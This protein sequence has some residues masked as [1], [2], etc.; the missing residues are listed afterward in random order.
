MARYLPHLLWCTS[1]ASGL[2]FFVAPNGCERNCS[3]SGVSLGLHGAQ[4]AVRQAIAQGMTEDI[5]VHIADGMYYLDKTLVFT[6]EDSGQR[7][8]T[9]RWKASGSNATISGGLR[10]TGWARN[11]TSGIYEASVPRG[12]QSRNLFVNGWA[13]NYARQELNHT[14]FTATNYTFNWNT[15]EYDW[16][17]TTPGIANAELR[18]IGSFTDRYAPINAV[19]DRELIMS[20]WC[21]RNQVMGYDDFAAPFADFGLF[22][23]NALALLDEGGEFFLDS[24]CGKVYYMPLQGEDMS[25][26]DTHLGILEALVVISGTY[27]SPAH[28]ISMEGLNFVSINHTSRLVCHDFGCFT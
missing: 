10:V 1:V 24:D 16:L 23:Q 19:G 7:G 20:Q 11:A 21:W 25:A 15:S 3:A 13:A 8:H 5:T 18:Q 17:M 22:V 12:T 26:A 9:V 14:S 27:D 28:D 4:G 6:G 2:D